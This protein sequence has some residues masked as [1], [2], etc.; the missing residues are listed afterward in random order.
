MLNRSSVIVRPK[1]PFLDWV[2]SYDGTRISPLE[3]DRDQTVYLIPEYLTDLD[4]HQ[5]LKRVY[6]TI[7]ELELEG[8]CLD[9]EKWPSIRTLGVF[10]E[11]F[12]VEFHSMVID[13]C[14]DPLVDDY[15]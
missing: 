14:G 4:A 8:W 6:E 13:L 3:V 5:V 11:W 15:A 10:M 2:N 1:Q 7:F 9:D 12:T